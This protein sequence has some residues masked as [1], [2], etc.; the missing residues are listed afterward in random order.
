[1]IIIIMV[2]KKRVALQRSD[3]GFTTVWKFFSK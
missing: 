2:I 3:F 1:M